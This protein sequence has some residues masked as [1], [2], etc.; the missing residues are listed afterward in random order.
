MTDTP[1]RPPGSLGKRL[2]LSGIVLITALLLAEAFVRALPESPSIRFTQDTDELRRLK[3]DRFAGV[4]INDRER[5]W[6]LVPG[7]TLPAPI[8]ETDRG[9]FFGVIANRQGFREDHEI[10]AVKPDNEVRLLFL[11]DSCTFGFGV[12]HD[13]TFVAHCE[14]R[15]NEQNPGHRFE[16][17]N[18]GVPGYTLFQ[19]CRVLDQEGPRVKPDVVV[20]CFGF[21]DRAAWDG[22][23]DLEHAAL[24]PPGFLGNSHL[25]RRLWRTNAPL[26][27][28]GSRPR[29][30]P[31]EYRQLLS[32]LH[33]RTR[34]LG[35]RL[36]LIAWCERFQVE[37]SRDERTPWQVELYR[38]AREHELPLVDLVPAM[39]KWNRPPDQPSLFLDI[40]HVTPA[41]HSRIAGLAVE[42]LVP[43]L[44]GGD[45]R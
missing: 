22:L 3:L 29:V 10:A 19:G 15:L 1:P 16:C 43:L 11:G 5:F 13:Q 45:A 25:A 7:S 27:G 18:A 41:A 26:A 30:T 23:G 6:R 2:A 4:L 42:A 28:S 36:A 37:N 35:S 24:G 34:Q 32:R 8:T 33:A 21:N 40:I 12:A 17:L 14:D 9:P 39:Q 44:P 20:A 31:A 38:F